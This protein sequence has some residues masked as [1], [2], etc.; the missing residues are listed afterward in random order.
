M[1]RKAESHDSLYDRLKDWLRSGIE[2]RAPGVKDSLFRLSDYLDERA[3]VPPK[4]VLLFLHAYIFALEH[5]SYYKNREIEQLKS[6]LSTHHILCMRGK[7]S[8]RQ[9]EVESEAR[10]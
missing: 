5:D 10:L 7:H 3:E 8:V 9:V 4:D 6:E 1:E 2:F